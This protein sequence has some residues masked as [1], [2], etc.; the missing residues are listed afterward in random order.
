TENTSYTYAVS[1]FDPSGNFS[2][3][4]AG[5]SATTLSGPYQ[6]VFPLK[7]SANGRYLVDQ[8]NVPFLMVGDAPQSTIG[9]LS[10]SSAAAFFAD[11]VAHGFNTL[12]INLLCDDYTFCN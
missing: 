10:T 1:A 8:N 4:S 12:W 5:A 2:A 7:A 3:Q 11:R 9:D 6:P